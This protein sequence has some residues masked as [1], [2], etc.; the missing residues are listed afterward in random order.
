[1]LTGDVPV[2][3]GTTSGLMNEGLQRSTVANVHGVGSGVLI[4]VDV[5][6]GVVSGAAS[7]VCT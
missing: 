6:A 5:A 3:P 2:A 7:L 1:V 4:G